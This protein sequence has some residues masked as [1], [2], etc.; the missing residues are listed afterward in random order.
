[1]A[2]VTRIES[3]TKERHAVHKPTHCLASVFMGP[4]NRHY[5]Q[6][7]TTGSEDREL[8]GK[9]S[10]SLQLNEESAAQLKQ[11][12]TEAFPGLR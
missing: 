10:Q 11:L 7:D 12:I 4:D 8:V 5:L 2:L 6:L 1:M 3:S 9:V